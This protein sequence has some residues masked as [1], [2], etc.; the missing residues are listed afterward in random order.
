MACL[1]LLLGTR[2]CRLTFGVFR[3]AGRGAILT[4][5]RRGKK[6]VYIAAGVNG[7]RWLEELED[8][9]GVLEFR[10]FQGA[11]SSRN[12][13]FTLQRTGRTL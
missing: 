12:P 8:V 10:V 9:V 5:K 3:F 7:R 2:F 1:L 6:W 11:E 4:G 13:I